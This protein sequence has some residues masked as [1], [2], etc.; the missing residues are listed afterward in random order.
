[1]LYEKYPLFI[2]G[3]MFFF[4]FFPYRFSILYVSHFEFDILI[5]VLNHFLLNLYPQ[6]SASPKE[7]EEK[8]EEEIEL[9]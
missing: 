6:G 2:S 4:Y 1:M 7:I 3:G 5:Q 9:L 8:R